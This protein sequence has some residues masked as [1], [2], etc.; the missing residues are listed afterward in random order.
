MKEPLIINNITQEE[1]DTFERIKDDCLALHLPIPP[2][3]S[4]QIQVH[5]SNGNLEYQVDALAKSWLRNGHNILCQSL[6]DGLN[7]TG[8]TATYA[9]GYLS[10]K[11]TS[12]TVANIGT[13]YLMSVDSV[14]NPSFLGSVATNTYG[15]QVGTS[16]T[17]ESFEHWG[18][19]AI[20]A[21]GTTTGTL[22]YAAQNAAS[23][24]YNAGTKTWTATYTRIFN[25]NSG[26]TIY[27]NETG[28]TANTISNSGSGI[29]ICLWRDLLGAS[30]TVNNGAQ[31]T[32]T[33]NVDY[34][35][36]S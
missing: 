8:G 7:N 25:N 33:Y 16:T 1:M 35:M 5:D 13:K 22:S 19:Q 24:N 27:V 34:V 29:K 9:A 3:T 14:G 26:G 10:C 36:P 28:M 18:L 15:I 17:A 23:F 12:G 6:M 11:Q 31:L 2:Q 32:V 4:Y 20:I 30:V 21:H